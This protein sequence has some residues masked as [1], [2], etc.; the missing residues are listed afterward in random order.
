LDLHLQFGLSPNKSA[1][2]LTFLLDLMRRSHQTNSN[3][4]QKVFADRQFCLSRGQM[5]A[6]EVSSSTRQSDFFPCDSQGKTV[7]PGLMKTPYLPII[8]VASALSLATANA[9]P[10]LGRETGKFIRKDEPSPKGV[11]SFEPAKAKDAQPKLSCG[12]PFR[13]PVALAFP[14][15]PPAT[16]A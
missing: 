5:M 1:Y 7:F 14:F 16:V 12:F 6:A 4:E 13:P 8:V 2:L 9:M 10:D 11:R 15:R 3:A